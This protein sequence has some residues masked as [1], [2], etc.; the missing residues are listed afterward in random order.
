ML[1]TTYVVFVTVG[2]YRR[3]WRYATVRDLLTIAFASCLA[4]VVALGIVLATRDLG[5]FP[6]RVFPAF[7]ALAA[8]L[9]VLSR[10]CVRLRPRGTARAGRRQTAGV[11][12]APGGRVAGSP[13]TSGADDAHVV[14]FRRQ[15]PASPPT[16]A[17]CPGHRDDRRCECGACVD[18][19]RRTRN[20][21]PRRVGGSPQARRA[22]MRCSADPVPDRA[23]PGHGSADDD[24]GDRRVSA[25]TT[26]PPLP[27]AATGARARLEGLLPLVGAYLLLATIY[28]W[29]A[30]RR[31]TP[32]IFTDEL[33]LT[34]ISRAIADVGEPIRRGE[35]YGFSSL[36]PWLTAPFWWLDPVAS[37]YEAIKTVQAFVMAAAIFPAYALARMVVTPPWA[38]FA[39]VA[40]IAA[41]A[42]SYAPILVEEP[43]A[44][45]A[46]TVALWLTVRA[47]DRPGRGSLALAFG[48][49]LLAVLIRSQ[50]AAVFGALAF[51]LLALGW[52]TAAMRRWRASWSRWDWVG[53][54]S[55]PAAP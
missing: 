35:P 15:S 10:W 36:I 4:S 6:L 26:A 14:G 50:L 8:G 45:P 39:A 27:R 18:A 19:R 5:D 47:V 23:R 13:A 9:A 52:R 51:G 24:A 32:T 16:R 1:G 34:Q 53:P 22:G 20:H 17:G 31:E 49:V 38:L 41:P 44:Y 28:A 54:S 29:Q 30:W 7:G 43:S 12:L 2:V 42:L 46:A 25:A 55:S 37:A 33:E 21:D 11:V 48:S 3:A 40:A